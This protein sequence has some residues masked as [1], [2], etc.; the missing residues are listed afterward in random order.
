LVLLMIFL[1]W[2]SLKD[3]LRVEV[4]ARRRATMGRA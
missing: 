2:W 3:K 1:L 4:E